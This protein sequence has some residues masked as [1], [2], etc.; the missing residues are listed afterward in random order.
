MSVTDKK[1]V[2]ILEMLEEPILST[3]ERL[4][5]IEK[6]LRRRQR[7]RSGRNKK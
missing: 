4:A 5:R 7:L 6:E 3:S 2:E 1:I